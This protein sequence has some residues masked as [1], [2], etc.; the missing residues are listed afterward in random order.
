MVD[1]SNRG[2]RIIGRHPHRRRR[3]LQ[4]LHRFPRAREEELLGLR[5]GDTGPRPAR[6]REAEGGQVRVLSFHRPR[7]RAPGRR[8]P[9]PSGRGS[10]SSTTI[11]S[12]RRTLSHPRLFN[13]WNY[14]Y[15]GG[16]R[17]APPPWP[18][19]SRRRFD[20]R[21]NQDLSPLALVGAL[22]DRQDKGEGR[23]LTGLNKV[24]VDD[25]VSKGLVSSRRTS[26]STEGRRGR[27]TRRSR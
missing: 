22:G 24:A 27:S 25:A 19:P 16:R 9:A 2:A 4:R 26:S 3:P 1:L 21:G 15:D 5:Q 23:S 13:A 8:S 10:W 12:P 7:V 18:T 6:D 20:D 11:R 17:P 14:G